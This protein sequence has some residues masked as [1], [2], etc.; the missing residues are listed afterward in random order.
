MTDALVNDKPQFVRLFTENGL[1]ILDYLTYRRLESLYRSLSDS[2]LA[3]TLLQR[4]LNERQSTAG[5]VPSVPT[6]L[7]HAFSLKAPES[8][9]TGPSSAKE[10][11]LYEV[12]PGDS[13]GCVAANVLEENSPVLQDSIN[14]SSRASTTQHS[15]FVTRLVLHCTV[16]NSTDDSLSSSTRCHDYYGISWGMSVSHFTTLL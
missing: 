7:D 11:S 15:A 13:C 9:L 14:T 3:Y 2:S 1:N 4:R 5:S 12:S 10:L 16:S 6:Q 8:P